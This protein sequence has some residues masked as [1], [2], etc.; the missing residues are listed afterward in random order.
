MKKRAYQSIFAGILAAVMLSVPVMAE[1]SALTITLNSNSPV[2]TVNGEEKAIDDRET[3]PVIQDNR[4]LLP[5]RAIAEEMGGQAEWDAKSQTVTLSKAEDTIRMQ[6]GSTTAYINGEAYTL[7][8]APAVIH[9]RTMLPIRFVA[10]SLGAEVVWNEETKTVTISAQVTEESKQEETAI[11]VAGIEKYGNLVL[12]LKGSELLED[13]AYGDVIAVTIADKTYAMPV[14]TNYSDVDIGNPVCR[15]QMDEAIPVD[16][17]VLALNM[18]NLAEDAGIAVKSE[19]AEEPGYQWDYTEG[20]TVPVKVS[21]A[22]Q[23]KGGYYNEYLLRQLHRTNERA[24]YAELSD[25][26]FAN[27]RMIDTTGMGAEKL[28]RSSSPVNPGLGRNGYADALMQKAGIKT[29]VNLADSAQAMTAYEGWATSYYAQCDSIGLHLGIPDT[30][31]MDKDFSD[32]LAEGLRFIAANESPYLIHCN[33]GKDRAGLVSALLECLMGASGEE[34]IADYMVTYSNYY[35]VEIG[36]EQYE[37]IAENNIVKMLNNIFGVADIR[38]EG[39]DLAAEAAECFRT[40]L[41]LTDAEI[42]AV[43]AK[44]K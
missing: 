36:S 21:I 42:E 8:A 10:E 27:F 29:V 44:L 31:K 37:E 7:D 14:G 35:G 26:E 17:V 4:I 23:E 15:V 22:M 18:G 38:A 20:M 6:I 11:T 25:A 43:Q 16:R 1:E 9:E 13:Y 30:Q 19:I 3:V 34:V 28:Y 5:V 2:M 12:S 33:E 40:Q 39:V 41:G 32:G 24:D